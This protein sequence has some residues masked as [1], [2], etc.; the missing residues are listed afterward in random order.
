MKTPAEPPPH[1]RIIGLY[2]ENSAAW[3]E[4][5]GTTPEIE[6]PWL[7][8]FASLL[9]AGGTILDLGCG[10]GAPMAADLIARGF[11][12]TG[13]DSSASMIGLCRAR[14][15]SQKWI[16]GDMRALD[17]GQRF[18]GAM[19]WHSS[20]HLTRDDQRALLP[21]LA[22]HVAPRGA[23]MF[24]SGPEDGVSIG[25]WRGEPLYHSSLAPDEYRALLAASG[26]SVVDHRVRDPECGEATIWIARRTG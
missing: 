18:D 22:D 4:I 3:A 13:V 9:P 8:R 11:H 26:F 19:A 20:F 12:V 17:L 24:T 21:R 5:R 15:P 14:F 16:V 2:E 1:E 25:E 10:S 6:R 7:D 23:L